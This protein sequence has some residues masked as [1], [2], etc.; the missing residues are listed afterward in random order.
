[1][2]VGT[3]KKSMTIKKSTT[4]NYIIFHIK[5]KFVE[6]QDVCSEIILYMFVIESRYEKQDRIVHS[7]SI[8]KFVTRDPNI[9]QNK[10]KVQVQSFQRHSICRKKVEM[11]K[12]KNKEKWKTFHMKGRLKHKLLLCKMI[13]LKIH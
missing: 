10:G 4:V 7:T 12:R 13:P 11:Q 3:Y 9:I 8:A 2:T 5:N 1:V 6:K